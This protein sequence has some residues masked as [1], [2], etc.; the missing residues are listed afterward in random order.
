MGLVCI[1]NSSLL[2]YSE[3]HKVWA[4]YCLPFQHSRGKNQPVGGFR[5]PPPGLFRVKLLYTLYGTNYKFT[6]TNYKEN[7]ATD[8]LHDKYFSAIDYAK[9]ARFVLYGVLYGA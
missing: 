7:V 8:R 1:Q 3:S 6:C 4:S 9:P 5:Q 2:I